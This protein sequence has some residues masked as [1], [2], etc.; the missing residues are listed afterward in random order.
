MM[1]E[2]RAAEAA[3][4]EEEYDDDDD[5]DDDDDEL[6]AREAFVG[7]EEELDAQLKE[8]YDDFSKTLQEYLRSVDGISNDPEFLK[9]M[10][11][12]LAAGEALF[13]EYEHPIEETERKNLKEVRKKINLAE[14]RLHMASFRAD[15][16]VRINSDVEQFFIHPD[17]R[18]TEDDLRLGVN[19]ETY[20]FYKANDAWLREQLDIAQDAG[21]ELSA[22][23]QGLLKEYEAKF[24]RLRVVDD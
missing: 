4:D 9:L 22:V 15:P 10:K 21:I 23:N 12:R 1:A 20:E 2:T 18:I 19:Q 7:T 14:A 13:A 17:T 8:Q 5:D 16:E 11:E 6:T 3:L 24:S